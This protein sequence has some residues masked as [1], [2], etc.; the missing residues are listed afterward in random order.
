M[1]RRTFLKIA[2]MGSVSFA[3]GCSSEPEKTLFSL[4]EAPDD[5]VTGKPSWYASTCREGPAGCGILAKNRAGRVVKLEGNPLHP[6]N[7]GKLCMRGQAALQGLYN[8]DRLRSPLLKENNQWQPISF[9]QAQAILRG[10]AKEAAER[11]PN[12]VRMMT[13]V[14]GETLQAL[15]TDALGQWQSP[16][17][18]IFEP[19]AYESIKAANKEIFGIEGLPSYHMDRADFLVSFGADFLETWLSPVEYARKFKSMH[20][21][22]NGEKGLFYHIGPYQSLTGANADLWIPCNPG[23]ETALALG[24]IREALGQGKGNRIPGNLRS[25]IESIA[26]PFDQATVL[27]TANISS[28]HYHKLLSRLFDSKKPLIIG[29]GTGSLGTHALQTNMAVNLLNFVLDPDLSRFD[30]KY[31]HRVELADKRSDAVAFLQILESES[32][33]LLFLNNVNPVFALPPATKAKEILSDASIF[34]ACFSSCLDETASV[35]DLI[36]PVRLPLESWGEY[37]GRNDVLSTLQPAMGM[38]TKA[39]DL[40]DVIL[41]I[42]YD[43]NRPAENYKTYVYSQMYQNGHVNGKADWVK[44]LQ[45]GGRFKN[46]KYPSSPSKPVLKGSLPGALKALKKPATPEAALLAVPSGRFYDGRGTN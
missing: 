42:A 1:N 20:A 29:T 6:I 41:N 27:K 12:R 45:A 2:G 5:M 22:H 4:V 21:I 17:P 33:D 39:P 10:K 13:E 43:T 7:Q 44:T 15:F 32:V 11:G 37:S 35:A 25:S 23:G 30:F 40:G 9:Q 24:S 36:L 19:Y 26:A 34:V 46:V 28:D 16:R 8:P 14:V 18:L 3:A 38:L 31:L